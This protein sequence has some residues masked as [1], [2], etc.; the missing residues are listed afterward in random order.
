MC[1]V[2][3]LYITVNYQFRWS[4]LWIYRQFHFLS[5]CSFFLPSYMPFNLFCSVGLTV[6]AV[7]AG[8]HAIEARIR[9]ELAC[10]FFLMKNIVF[11]FGMIG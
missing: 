3:E 4:I 6:Y 9:M 2:F 1:D 5:P 8:Q 11:L 7:S 10:I